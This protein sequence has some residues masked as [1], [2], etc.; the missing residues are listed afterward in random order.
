[1]TPWRNFILENFNPLSL[2]LLILRVAKICPFF[3]SASL[4]CK[5]G[6]FHKPSNIKAPNFKVNGQVHRF[7]IENIIAF[8]LFISKGKYLFKILPFRYSS[9]HFCFLW[10]FDIKFLNICPLLRSCSSRNSARSKYVSFPSVGTHLEKQS[11][12][13]NN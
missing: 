10:A 7:S 5:N 4:L 11:A 6:N 8:L 13:K 9:F 1:L 3:K 12:Q 2:N